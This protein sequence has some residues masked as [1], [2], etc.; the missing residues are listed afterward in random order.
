MQPSW[1]RRYSETRVRAESSQGRVVGDG[2]GSKGSTWH[3]RHG[4]GAEQEPDASRGTGRA[5]EESPLEESRTSSRS[6]R[7]GT[8]AGASRDGSV[9]SEPS[10]EAHS[11]WE[12]TMGASVLDKPNDA[13]A[14]MEEGFFEES[15]SR[16]DASSGPRTLGRWEKRRPSIEEVTAGMRKV[17]QAKPPRG[18]ESSSR[19][20]QRG[21]GEPHRPAVLPQGATP[22]P[23]LFVVSH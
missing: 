20:E 17:R 2:D 18:S 4:K 21:E 22:P 7:N 16:L 6:W 1:P 19:P 9:V 14:A 3:K 15:L 23:R 10:L 8:S 13:V 11:L 5:R 12:L